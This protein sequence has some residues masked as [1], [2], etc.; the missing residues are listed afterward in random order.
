[1][2]VGVIGLGF[3]AHVHVPALRA[4][5]NVEVVAI[6]GS[7]AEH[8]AAAAARLGIANACGGYRELL[9]RD[10]LDAVTTA[11][12]S[13][14]NGEALAL[15]LARRL[16]VLSEKPV[17]PAGTTTA[18]L[19][20]AA[21]G[22]TT[23]VDF[24]FAELETFKCL[25]ALLRAGEL[26]KIHSVHV[27]WTAQSY[28]QRNRQWSWKTDARNGGGVLSML[29]SHMVFL[30][31]WLL[32]PIE[33]VSVESSNDT[34]VGFAPPGAISAE[35]TVRLSLR[36]AGGFA[37]EALLS[38]SDAGASIHRWTVEGEAATAVLENA[39]AD[40][41]A[42]FRLTR[43]ALGAAAELLHEERA[44]AG[45]NRL[46]AVQSLMRRFVDGARAGTPVKPDLTV[47]AR[48][49]HVLDDIRAQARSTA[50]PRA[51]AR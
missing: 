12:P 24:M 51:K 46:A 17:S 39:S 20:A 2:R 30:V 8:A 9:A 11:L 44:A 5:P 43:Q 36:A 29:G 21:S 34:T 4:C 25:R 15:A 40:Y 26:G 6:A 10:D 41:V 16:P 1:M 23:A 35:D 27:T 50:M 47:A 28:A 48:I 22:I 32:G 7:T 37:I 18:K 49:D 45:D 38:N 13:A 42:G 3:G 14:A 33:I 31:E 19:A